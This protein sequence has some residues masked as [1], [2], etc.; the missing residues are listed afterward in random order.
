MFSQSFGLEDIIAVEGRSA[1]QEHERFWI[2][3]TAQLTAKIQS[4]RKD[5]VLLASG[6]GSIYSEE[7]LK[8]LVIKNTNL[9]EEL[10]RLIRAKKILT[11]LEYARAKKTTSRIRNLIIKS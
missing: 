6:L 8:T 4:L 9:F 7:V 2:Y 3:S 5:S 1:A 10:T 11:E